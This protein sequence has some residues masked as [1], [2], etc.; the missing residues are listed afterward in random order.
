M[1]GS[2]IDLSGSLQLLPLF[3][4]PRGHF[5]IRSDD[6]IGHFSGSFQVFERAFRTSFSEAPSGSL[7]KRPRRG[8]FSSPNLR[9]SCALR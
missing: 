8:S 1:V 7:K 3:I 4:E 2:Y 6:P 9:L 5:L